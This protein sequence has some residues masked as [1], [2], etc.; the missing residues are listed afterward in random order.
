M[1]VSGEQKAVEAIG[2]ALKLAETQHIDAAVPMFLAALVGAA[3]LPN[4]APNDADGPQPS[5]S[6]RDNAAEARHQP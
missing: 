1:K 3:Y 5:I 6:H 2:Q 4:I